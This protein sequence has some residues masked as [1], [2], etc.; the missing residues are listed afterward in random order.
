MDEDQV[1]L[2]VHLSVSQSAEPDPC[3]PTAAIEMDSILTVKNLIIGNAYILL[4]YAFFTHVP[5]KAHVAAFL[6]SNYDTKHVFTATDTTY[7]YQDPKKIISTK[8][9]YYRCVPMPE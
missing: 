6:Q 1:T 2:P 8:S 3:V 7:V 5:T 4:R 9:V